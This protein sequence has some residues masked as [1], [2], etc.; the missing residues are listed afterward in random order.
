M[1]RLE[2]GDVH[3]VR[4]AEPDKQRPVIVLTR[5]SSLDHLTKV[6][7]APITSTIRGTPAE[8]VLDV[9]DGMKGPCVANLFNVS[10]VHR[11]SIGRRVATLSEQRMKEVC[12]A[13]RF[14]M[15][16]D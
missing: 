12:S 8:I 16:C 1:A 3:L 9:A 6:T 7:V 2:R 14:A 13:L 10:T 15:G 11:S 5:A 4:F